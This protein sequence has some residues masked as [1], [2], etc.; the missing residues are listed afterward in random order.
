VKG[1]KQLMDWA[2]T[3][4]TVR[5]IKIKI[6][7]TF[8]LVILWA[9]Y[10]WGV[11]LRRGSS[12]ALF[13]IALIAVL[14]LCVVLHELAHSFVAM[15]YGVQVREIEL[16]PIGGV[17][18]MD[19][20]PAKPYQEFVMALAGPLVNLALAVPLGLMVLWMV[21][22]GFIRSIG[23]LVYLMGKP[24]WQGFILNLFASNILLALFN[25]IPAFPMDGGRILRS[26]LA[27]G[28]GQRQATRWAV[29]VGQGLASL[30]AVAGLLSGNLMLVLI[31]IV[32]SVG[33]HQ[34]GRFTDLQAVLGEMQVGQA[35]ITPCPILSS[36]DTLQV[37]ME[38]ALHGHAAPFAVGEEDRLVG[39]LTQV[40]IRSALATYGPD[41]RVGDIMQRDFLSLPP[42]DTLVHARQVM[43]TSG[44]RALPVTAEGQLM[45]I[46]TAQHIQEI[47]TLLAAQEQ[48]QKN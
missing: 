41:A 46:V 24:S 40:D 22:G 5:G 9:A 13:G 8:L 3:L 32:V 26:T 1:D 20:L 12:G 31:A 42:T 28:I 14:F 47:Y 34:E 37:V 10:N 2:F 45:G 27:W 6:H 11:T 23:H 21:R 16:S 25:L 35:L 30:M 38:R 15:F 19:E 48:R 44:L 36:D 39:W 33:A 18:K 4:G 17:A 43:A 29:R 7:L